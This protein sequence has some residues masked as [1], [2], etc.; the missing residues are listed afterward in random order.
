[1]VRTSGEDNAGRKMHKGFTN[2]GILY[3]LWIKPR[4]QSTNPRREST[5]DL[6]AIHG[7][8]INVL[9][10]DCVDEFDSFRILNFVGHYKYF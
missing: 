5:K 4:L 7:P 9:Y 1:M 6:K 8:W 3:D 10:V 2:R